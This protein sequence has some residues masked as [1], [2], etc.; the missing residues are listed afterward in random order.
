ML[1]SWY[2]LYK[3][4]F[5]IQ[6]KQLSEGRV[7]VGRPRGPSCY[8]LPTESSDESQCSRTAASGNSR[9]VFTRGVGPLPHLPALL[10]PTASVCKGKMNQYYFH[11]HSTAVRAKLGFLKNHITKLNGFSQVSSCSLPSRKAVDSEQT[12]NGTISGYSD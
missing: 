1:S 9:T 6:L 5:F 2:W 10:L 11:K 7:H 4:A 8:K 3:L 12:A